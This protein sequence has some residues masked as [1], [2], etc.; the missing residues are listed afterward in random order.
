MPQT[1][2]GK[3]RRAKGPGTI[4]VLTDELVA[5]SFLLVQDFKEVGVPEHLQSFVRLA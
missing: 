5:E 1:A 3:R 4:N 2:N